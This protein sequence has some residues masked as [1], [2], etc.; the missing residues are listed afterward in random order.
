MLD[1]NT[2]A[3]LSQL[4][5][6]PESVEAAVAGL[7]W[8]TVVSIAAAVPTAIVARRK[9]RSVVGWL[10]F[11]LTIPVLPLLIVWLLPARPPKSDV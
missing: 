8:L 6:A 11:A 7:V 2:A 1:P 3:L 10:V 4:G 5:V 9:R